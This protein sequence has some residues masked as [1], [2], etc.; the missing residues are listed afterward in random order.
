MNL[1]F[2]NQEAVYVNHGYRNFPEIKP[3]TNL[4]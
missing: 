2:Y 1:N 4:E 3:L